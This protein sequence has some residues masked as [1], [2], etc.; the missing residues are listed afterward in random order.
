HGT[1]FTSGTPPSSRVATNW[2]NI[3]TYP[4]EY[5]PPWTPEM[6]DWSDLPFVETVLLALSQAVYDRTG[7]VDW[8][9]RDAVG[10]VY[11]IEGTGKEVKIGRA[12]NPHKRMVE[13]QIGNPNRLN[14]WRAIP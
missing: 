12:L 9:S 5:L 13:L 8:L 6:G 3:P 11:V 1:A 2:H 4:L 7:R 10:F 14:I